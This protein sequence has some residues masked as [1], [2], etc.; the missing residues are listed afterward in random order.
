[1]LLFVIHTLTSVAF[2]AYEGFICDDCLFSY[3]FLGWLLLGLILALLFC[4]FD[5]INLENKFAHSSWHTNFT[6]VRVIYSMV[7][8]AAW[9]CSVYIYREYDLSSSL[10]TPQDSRIMNKECLFFDYYDGNDLFSL[11]TSFAMLGTTY[12]V[13]YL[14]YPCVECVSSHYG[15]EYSGKRFSMSMT[16][17]TQKSSSCGHSGCGSKC[18]RGS[19]HGGHVAHN[20][21]GGN[22]GRLSCGCNG[23]CGCAKKSCGCSIKSIC[24]C[25][26]REA[27][28]RSNCKGGCPHTSFSRHDSLRHT[29]D[30]G[31]TDATGISDDISYINVSDD[32]PDPQII[33]KDHEKSKYPHVV[34]K[35]HDT[36]H[37]PA[38]LY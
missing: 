13:M 29:K 9:A 37:K 12:L 23:S 32:A 28:K 3:F 17:A 34:V 19:G 15:I 24:D 4:L 26:Q 11:M 22:G 7:V 6:W 33:F 31:M 25:K 21:H 38:Y 2:A 20:A 10:K 8:I 36:N 5:Q 35:S 14:N 16:D 18:A 1:M 27:S 30:S